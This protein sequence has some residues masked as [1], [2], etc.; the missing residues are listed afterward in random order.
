MG[1]EYGASLVQG[2]GMAEEGSAAR[3]G[4]LTALTDPKQAQ[5]AVDDAFEKLPEDLKNLSRPGRPGYGTLG[6]KIRVIANH[7]FVELN[8][9]AAVHY[10]VK[11]QA[12]QME[13]GQDL[14]ARP[15]RDKPVPRPVI[16]EVMMQLSQHQGWPLGWAFDGQRNLFFPTR[17]LAEDAKDATFVVR[18]RDPGSHRLREFVVEIREVDVLDMVELLEFIR[19]G[20]ATSNRCGLVRTA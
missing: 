11:I 17:L 8:A 9:K 5:K 3:P 15:Q 7:F 6:R 1:P 2:T 4:K 19:H 10:D 12:V 14:P 18:A 13:A 20:W 16:K